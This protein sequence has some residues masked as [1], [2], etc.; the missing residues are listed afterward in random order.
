M[1]RFSEI[2]ATSTDMYVLFYEKTNENEE[3]IYILDSVFCEL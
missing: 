3:E 1:N 2:E